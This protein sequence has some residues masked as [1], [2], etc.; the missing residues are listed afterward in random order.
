MRK[1]S[2]DLT[3]G[4][5]CGVLFVSLNILLNELSSEF[6]AYV[7]RN[8]FAVCIEYHTIITTC[9]SISIACLFCGTQRGCTFVLSIKAPTGCVIRIQMTRYMY[10]SNNT[11]FWIIW[12]PY[13]KPRVVMM[14]NLSPLVQRR[15]FRRREATL[16]YMRKYTVLY[17][18]KSWWYYA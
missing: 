11:I 5:L 17:H 8:S 3:K 18:H 15:L 4:Q 12:S 16:M 14:S 2:G 9:S 10:L 6:I 7:Y 1:S 13:M